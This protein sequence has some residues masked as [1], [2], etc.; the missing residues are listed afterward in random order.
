MI[1]SSCSFVCFA[2]E[3][4]DFNRLSNNFQ[5]FFGSVN[6]EDIRKTYLKFY[7]YCPS[8]SNLAFLYLGLPLCTFYQESNW[9]KRPLLQGQL[10]YAAL[11]CFVL[12]NISYY[13]EKID[14]NSIKERK[15]DA[16]N[17]PFTTEKQLLT[18]I[19]QFSSKQLYFLETERKI[20][21]K[22]REWLRNRKIDV[23]IFFNT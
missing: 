19:K 10:Y 20:V 7:D 9:N 3:Q 1:F 12:Y 4:N 18:K 8:L 13:L 16:D 5:E 15:L 2:L 14:P 22:K 23:T 17:Y 6:I 11:D 21:D